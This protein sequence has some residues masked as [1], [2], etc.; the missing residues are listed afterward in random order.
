MIENYIKNLNASGKYNRSIAV[1]VAPMVKFWPAED[2]PG[3]YIHNPS[4]VM[5]KMYLFL[6]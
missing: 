5:F 6:K 1:Q 4:V 3:L 2:T